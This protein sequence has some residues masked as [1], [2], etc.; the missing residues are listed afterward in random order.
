MSEIRVFKRDDNWRVLYLSLTQEEQLTLVATLVY[1]LSFGN[2]LD[3]LILMF[4]PYD[5]WP[6]ASFITGRLPSLY[7]YVFMLEPDQGFNSWRDLRKVGTFYSNLVTLGKDHLIV[8]EKHE[9]DYSS[10]IDSKSKFIVC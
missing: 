2:S 10:V 4:N 8:G 3:I 6:D 1:R 5:Y 9:V 7:K